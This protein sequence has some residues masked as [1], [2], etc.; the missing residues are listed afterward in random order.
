MS[1]QTIW[2]WKCNSCMFYL[3]SRLVVFVF[4]TCVFC[5][6]WTTLVL[7]AA[8]TAIWDTAVQGWDMDPPAIE[9]EVPT[10]TAVL[11][12]TT[13]TAWCLHTSLT[14]SRA[15]S[16]LLCIPL[17]TSI[18]HLLK[19]TVLWPPLT[20]HLRQLILH[21]QF[22]HLSALLQFLPMFRPT[23]IP[24]SDLSGN[25]YFRLF[26]ESANNTCI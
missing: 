7:T 8:Q 3:T 12:L 2:F 20:L 26:G 24:V 9:L 11:H 19:H 14:G 18:Q 16:N 1:F 4:S 10:V 6:Q 15:T 13:P 21:I 25:L 22:L 5:F 17:I 23:S